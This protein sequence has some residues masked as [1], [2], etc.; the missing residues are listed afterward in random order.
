MPNKIII[1]AMETSIFIADYIIWHYTRAFADIAH[2]TGNFL[3]FGYNFFSIPLL[4]R[5]LFKPFHRIQDSSGRGLDLGIIAQ[6]FIF[7]TAVRVIGA[8][9]RICVL[10]VGIAFEIAVAVGA[11]LTFI[12]WLVLPALVPAM[13]VTGILLMVR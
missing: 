9:L 12:V 7:N 8:V 3:L 2:L 1:D 6:N 11:L 5:T 4:L 13:A 10:T